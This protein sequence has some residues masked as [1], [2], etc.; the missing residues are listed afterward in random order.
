MSAAP[1]QYDPGQGSPPFSPDALLLEVTHLRTELTHLRDVV[2]TQRNVIASLTA[3]RD[4]HKA[5][6]DN[7]RLTPT[8]KH[9]LE[10]VYELMGCPLGASPATRPHPDTIISHQKIAERLGISPK[11]VSRHMADMDEDRWLKRV[12]A[13]STHPETG[14]PITHYYYSPVEGE[15]YL[16]TVASP[17]QLV[18]G[19]DPTTSKL[20]ADAKNA[21]Q[22]RKLI[23]ARCPVCKTTDCTIHCSKGHV[24]HMDDAKEARPARHLSLVPCAHP[25]PEAP[26]NSAVREDSSLTQ[27]A[28]PVREET[29]PLNLSSDGMYSAD[30]STAMAEEPVR[31]D[32]SLTLQA[33]VAVLSPAVTRHPDAV[34][35]R[36]GKPKYLSIKR[37]LAESDIEAHLRGSQTYGAGVLYEVGGRTRTHAV[38]WDEDGRFDRLMRA[39]ARLDDAGLRPLLCQNPANPER[40]HLWL[41]FS[42]P[43]DPAWAI[44]AAERLAPELRDVDERF[45]DLKEKGGARVRLP[46]GAYVTADGRR[47]PTRIAAGTA[48][49][50]GEWL[51]GTTP[52]A[53]ALIGMALSNPAILAA[54]FVPREERPKPRAPWRPK[55]GVVIRAPHEDNDIFAQFNT[56]NPIEHLVDVSRENKFK[57]PW[58]DE[59]TPSVHVYDD[60]HWHDFGPD[61]RHGKD[62]FDLW[63]A[64]RGYWDTGANKPDRK[65]GI[66]ALKTSG[67][68]V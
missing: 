38:V 1:H 4:A 65:A 67:G 26:D 41:L 18:E 13:T 60:G 25:T 2:D 33:A 17:S 62:A 34:R 53:W 8:R 36:G 61:G 64:L 47:L 57:A 39:A 10:V 49:G 66:A 45:P 22:K 43:C 68:V 29:S 59:A 44:A 55:H 54:T 30:D 3:E 12:K 24:T 50:P 31:E 40:G 32:S 52:A 20:A 15:E 11:Q 28:A 58:R 27:N 6:R 56:Q 63:C 5:L 37:A 9:T 51:D 21:E 19:R 14:A 48:D 46:G 23:E 35:M 16:A 42:A 7:P